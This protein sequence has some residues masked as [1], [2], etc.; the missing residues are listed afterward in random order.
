MDVDQ[1]LSREV[2]R[3]IDLPDTP[4]KTHLLF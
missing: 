1:K 3:R 4:V 2:K